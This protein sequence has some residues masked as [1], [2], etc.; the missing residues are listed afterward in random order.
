MPATQGPKPTVLLQLRGDLSPGP[1]GES[2]LALVE[3]LATTAHARLRALALIGMC[4]FASGMAMALI[5]PAMLGRP[6]WEQ[7]VMAG[8]C[9]FL[10]AVSCATW[11]FARQARPPARTIIAVGLTYVVVAALAMACAE[12]AIGPRAA[13]DYDGVPGMCIWIVLFPLII[14]CLPSQALVAALNCATCLPLAYGLSLMMGREPS[15]TA[16]LVRWFAPGYFC[17]GVAWAAA[18]VFGRMAGDV[19]RSRREV[20]NLGAYQLTEMLGRGGMGEVWK[21]KHRLLPRHAAVKFIRPTEDPTQDPAVVRDIALRF[22]R[23]AKAI[24]LLQSPHTVQLYDFGLSPDGHLYYA[25]ELLDGF[26]LET[27]V[28]RHGPLPESRVAQLLAQACLSLAEA[29]RA[30]LVHRDIK[31]GNI[32]LCR[33]GEDLDVVKVLDFGLVGAAHNHPT[34]AGSAHGATGFA[35]TPGYIAPELIF[36]AGTASS[37]SDIYGLGAVA[38]WLLTGSTL[39]PGADGNEDLVAHSM[40]TP[41]L[42]SLRLGKPINPDLERLIMLCLNK[43]PDH[44]PPSA[45]AIR[46][47]LRAM[48]F[49]EPWSD[50]SAL[51]WWAGHA[52]GSG[53]PARPTSTVAI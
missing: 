4:T 9:A 21:A 30:G 1:A 32:M 53:G 7:L 14:P 25:M 39:F 10:S 35:G 45:L 34:L 51:A 29:H 37:A 23:E 42:P 33:L 16:A 13:K 36:G 12:I 27:L 38:Y 17:A 50:A 41:K 8:L 43:R 3:V 15:D 24:A 26:D 20:Q 40:D 5:L 11:M 52:P 47:R 18:W 6:P 46:D 31:P 28:A 44:R 48:N 19:A 2:R 49:A 22:Q